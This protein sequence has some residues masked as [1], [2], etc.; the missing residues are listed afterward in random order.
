MEG[1]VPIPVGYALDT[2]K[3]EVKL[4]CSEDF[5]QA[6]KQQQGTD[7]VVSMVNLLISKHERDVDKYEAKIGKLKA[8]NWELKEKLDA[9]QVLSEYTKF[10][11]EPQDKKVRKDAGTQIEVVIAGEVRF[12]VEHEK[13]SVK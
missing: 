8:K 13:E 7:Q 5:N 2:S 10:P 11:E 3:P 6:A 1:Q 12:Q 4:V 9:V